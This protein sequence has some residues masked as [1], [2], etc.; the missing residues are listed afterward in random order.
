MPS[1]H[2]NDSVTII[3]VA[4]SAELA[5]IHFLMSFSFFKWNEAASLSPWFRNAER[6]TLAPTGLYVIVSY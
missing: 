2:P 3:A 5:D 6:F 4:R 1:P